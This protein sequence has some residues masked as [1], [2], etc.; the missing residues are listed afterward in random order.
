MFLKTT[1]SRFREAARRKRRRAR[2]SRS[3]A[4]P[5][6]I[7]TESVPGR[8]SG[9]EP[10]RSAPAR[11]VDHRA[12]TRTRLAVAAAELNLKLMRWRLLPELDLQRVTK[13]KCLLI[14]RDASDARSR[15]RFGWGVREFTVVDSG[16]VSFSNPTRQ[17][18]FEFSDCL[19]GGKPKAEAA[20]AN[21]ARVFP[22][23]RAR[24]VV[25]AVPMPGH[26]VSGDDATRARADVERL[27]ALVK[28][29]DAVFCLTDTRESRWLPTR[30]PRTT[31]R[32]S[33]PRS[34]STRTWSC[35]PR[36]RD[37]GAAREA[38]FSREQEVRAKTSPNPK[39]NAATTKTRGFFH[40]G[41]GVTSATT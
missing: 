34:G 18:L 8:G 33:T 5:P 23:V 3:P 17:S 10:A 9:V 38:F 22:G 41:S 28:T 31:S 26:P 24:G 20:A 39:T 37:G 4:E 40:R 25:M 21:L 12:W 2:I 11:R 15:E 19:D 14:G 29:H 6:R 7:N 1:L 30:S 13:T 35:A 36:R 32:S 27:E 16:R